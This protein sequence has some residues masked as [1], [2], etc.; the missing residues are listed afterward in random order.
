MPSAT[1]R[2]KL[3]NLQDIFLGYPQ[4]SAAAAGSK[5]F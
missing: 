2:K 1:F 4:F 5:D 3:F